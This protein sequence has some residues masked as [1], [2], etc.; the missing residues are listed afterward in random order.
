M[1]MTAKP[2]MPRLGLMMLIVLGV[3]GLALVAGLGLQLADKVKLLRAAPRDNTQYTLF[4]T[5][6][7]YMA[8]KAAWLES[9]G[10]AGPGADDLRKRFDI[11]Y[12]RV[13]LLK[14]WSIGRE[15]R[16][17]PV[18]SRH[19]EN[20]DRL[21]NN[22]AAIIDAGKHASLPGWQQL[23]TQ[24]H[25]VQS[26]V[27]G[28]VH[29]SLQQFALQSDNERAEFEQL[30]L[31]LA[32]LVTF[33][34]LLLASAMV[35]M[36]RKASTLRKQ[37]VSLEESRQQLQATVA[38]ALDAVIIA[39]K[40]GC[41]VDWNDEAAACFG[42]RREQAV[43]R[44]MA[45]LIVPAAMRGA[46]EA[47]MKRYLETGEPR[48]IG[49][50][51]EINAQ[52]ATGHEF[53]I[54]LA[55]GS[56]RTSSGPIFIAFA[57]D[58]SD[59]KA[60]QEELSVAAERAKAGEKAKSAFLAVMSHEMRTPLNGILGT[61]ELMCDTPLNPR[62]R[63]LVETANMSGELLLD[64][65]NNVLDLSKMDAGKLELRQ[66]QFDLRLMLQQLHQII[67]PSLQENSNCISITIDDRIPSGIETDPS[68][69]R[70]AIINLLSNANKFTSHGSVSI[71]C[72]LEPSGTSADQAL[73][74]FSVSDTGIGIPNHRLGELF[75]EFSQIDPSFRRRQGGTGLGLSITRRTVEAMGGKIGFTST[76][77][78]G[79][80]FW[81]TVPVGLV[82]SFAVSH[83]DAADSEAL[84][85]PAASKT[86]GRILVAE[87]NFTNAMV[88]TDMLEAA[89][90]QVV[91][92][93]NGKEAVAAHRNGK[94]DLVLMDISMPE[95]DGIEATL[96]IR[97]AELEDGKP[98]LPIVALT[99]NAMPDEMERFHMAGMD[100]CLTKP[101]RKQKL[102][103]AV[104]SILGSCDSPE[105][106]AGKT[107]NTQTTEAPVIDHA[108]LEELEQATNPALVARVLDKYLEE[109]AA[110]LHAARDAAGAGDLDTLQKMAH[111]LS[112]SSSTVGACRLQ[113]LVASIEAH[114][115]NGDAELALALARELENVGMET[116]QHYASLAEAR[117]A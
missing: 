12:S 26:D 53:P 105:Q 43:G 24:I 109:A 114:C 8:L 71:D 31:A 89:G 49:N 40:D 101:I 93:K 52:H 10:R 44:N 21:L 83:V 5:Q 116:C 88:V 38:S 67:A 98:P 100:G 19:L 108:V 60:K 65:I 55:V 15:V 73:L 18:V 17:D 39:D 78:Y 47:G 1:R 13:N 72:Q 11:F 112:G 82:V 41:I 95:M 115:I 58:I 42:Y 69:L 66:E 79:S 57:R 81:F 56:A 92:A 86:A 106:E 30:Y 27:D 91:H 23:G 45:E 74:R 77:G 54:E 117:A 22:G 113:Q 25:T 34:G 48:V 3:V 62:Q 6:T 51:I 7:E 14:T 4:Q 80:T 97:A 29:R 107:M 76:E 84:A 2:A 90:H 35:N 61:L 70:Q 111:S 20:L 85:A 110:K 64:L 68:R 33:L 104:Q 37:S 28:I 103:D 46:H 87:D 9:G 32:T 99:A 16:R 96:L 36:Q 59:R 50:R 102:L 63:A 94:F 75:Q